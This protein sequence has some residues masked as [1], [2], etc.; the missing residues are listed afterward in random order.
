MK[1]IGSFWGAAVMLLLGMGLLIVPGAA[2][3]QEDVPELQKNWNLR[4]GLFIPQ[5]QTTRSKAGEVGFSGIVERTV[6]ETRDYAI[7]VGIGYNG[8]GDVYSIPITVM[9]IAHKGNLRYG[10]GGGYSFGK[11]IDGRGMSGA[12]LSVLLGYQLTHGTMPLNAD[13]RY[14]FISGADQELDGYSFTIGTRF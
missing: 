4:I 14:N 5:S 12:V 7:N 13:L 11:R 6:Y 2:R 8:F 10:V 1:R 3:A 9:G